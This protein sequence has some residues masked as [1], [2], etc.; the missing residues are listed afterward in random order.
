MD[1][2]RG[3]ARADSALARRMRSQTLPPTVARS[4]TPICETPSDAGVNGNSRS[5]MCTAYLR[6]LAQEKLL[7]LLP[8]RR[9]RLREAE[10]GAAAADSGD[11]V[12]DGT[13]APVERVQLREL[14]ELIVKQ[15]RHEF[16]RHLTRTSQSNDRLVNKL[17]QENVELRASI[18]ALEKRAAQ[19]PL[20]KERVGRQELR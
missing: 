3:K 2:A 16:Q 6:E 19:C 4:R 5:D 9:S 11:R 18:A 12:G 14:Q 1:V 8:H 20:C 15:L 7:K 10:E 13:T 17:R